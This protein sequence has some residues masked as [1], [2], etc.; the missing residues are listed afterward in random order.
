MGQPARPTA[1][2]LCRCARC[3]AAISTKRSTLASHCSSLLRASLASIFEG[4]CKK[5]TM[6]PFMEPTPRW[7]TNAQVAELLAI[8]A[9]T[10]KRWM[11]CPEKRGAIGA[12]RHGKQWR[13]PYTSDESTWKVHARHSLEKAGVHLKPEWETGLRQLGRRSDRYLVESYRL[14]LAAYINALERGRVTQQARDNMLLLWQT[15]CKV[16][17]PPKR[18]KRYEVDVEKHKSHFAP[19]LRERGLKVRSIMHYWPQKR[20]LLRSLPYQGGPWRRSA[21]TRF[22]A[23]LPRRVAPTTMQRAQGSE[24]VSFTTRT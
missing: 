14:W 15:A 12:V 6:A 19:K 3:L 20:H 17:D 4:R 2:L 11:R 7:L 9:R 23:S 10:I 22:L 1:N 21:P 13:I 24:S 5:T 8:S 16:L 18:L